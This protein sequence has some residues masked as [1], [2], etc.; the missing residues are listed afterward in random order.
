MGFFRKKTQSALKYIADQV[1]LSVVDLIS[2]QVTSKLAN[3]VPMAVARAMPP[4]PT[5]PKATPLVIDETTTHFYIHTSD[6]HRFFLDAN[7]HHISLHVMEYGH[8]ED[9]VRDVMMQILKPGSTFV[10]VGGNVGLHT[11]F[12]G[13]IVGTGGKVFVFEP[14][15]HMFNTLKLNIDINGMGGIITPYQMAVSDTEEVRS[16]SNFRSH[17]A[18]SGFTVPQA[19]LDAFNE[20]ENSSVEIIEV[21]TTTIDKKFAGQRIDGLKIDVEGYEALV[22]RGAHNV[23]KDN[24]DIKLIIEWEPKLVERTQGSESMA[25]SVAFFRSQGFIPYLAQWRE[26]L[27]Q[28]SWDEAPYLEKGDLILS[29]TAN[30]R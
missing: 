5:P 17:S 22:V 15:P 27:K 21:Q 7:D 9:H 1:S 24:L 29:R 30:L 26:S 20:S 12:A 16:F 23:I 14:L 19:R 18:M 8:W 11:L 25:E 28:V 4:Y 6:G 3:S 13:S 2:D 10:D